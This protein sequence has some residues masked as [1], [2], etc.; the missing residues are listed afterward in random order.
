VSRRADI[1]E[2]PS[3]RPG[4]TLFLL[5]LGWAFGPRG[6]HADSGRLVVGTH[7]P[8]LVSALSVAVSPRGLSVVELPEPLGRVTD[9]VAARRE[10]TVHDAVAV[11]WLCDDEAGAHALCFCDRDGR[12]VV[13]PVSV[14][15][16]LAPPDA[17]AL[18]LS[19][20][21][22][23]G[24]TPP[25]RGP[26]PL[27][28][29]ADVPPAHPMPVTE[30]KPPPGLPALAVEITGGARIQSP[31][32]QHLGLRVGLKGLFAPGRLDRNLGVGVGL[33][34]GPALAAGGP[35]PPA[36]GTRR[37]VDDLA[38]S[39]VARGRL[40]LRALWLELDLGPSAH[41]LSVDAGPAASRRTDLS[42]D[43]LL[44]VVL[45]AGRYFAGLR[46]G[47]FA[48][49]TSAPGPAGPSAPLALPR[50]NADAILTIGVTFR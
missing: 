48:M 34:T 15:S 29:R 8:T 21:V 17:A 18:A 49:L 12:L 16:P 20:K 41:F 1:R 14:A 39:V 28:A 33:T 13:K 43:A 7:D 45:P 44:G 4:R 5:S 36:P 50:W 35:P 46:A 26:L 6:A 3:F 38:L 27:A 11:V 9:I 25:G 30:V 2:R 32:A 19:V 42:F 23:L 47:G 31:A 24:A 10:V 40:R 37:T 22:L